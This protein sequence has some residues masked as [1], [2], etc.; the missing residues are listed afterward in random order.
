[1]NRGGIRTANGALSGQIIREADDSAVFFICVFC[2]VIY[3]DSPKRP[4]CY[5][6]GFE[7]GADGKTGRLGDRDAKGER[8]LSE[9]LN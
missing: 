4:V 8:L 2:R 1:M 5:L 7:A 9:P 6:C 3:P